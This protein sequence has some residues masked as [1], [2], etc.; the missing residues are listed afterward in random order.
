MEWPTRNGI[1]LPTAE[2]GLPDSGLDPTKPESFNNHHYEWTARKMGQF[3]I[4][5]TLR[6]LEGLQEDIPRDLHLWLHQ[7]YEP[8]KFP[9]IK[10][11]L[12]RVVMGYQTGEMLITPQ[13]SQAMLL[14]PPKLLTL[15]LQLLKLLTPM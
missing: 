7:N 12:A 6:D 15:I 3:L 11:A 2:V 10:Q 5:Q 13:Y 9:T 14:Q 1:S 4:T 8:P